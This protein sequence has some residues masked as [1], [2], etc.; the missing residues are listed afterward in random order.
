M[1]SKRTKY[2]ITW[3]NL[4]ITEVWSLAICEKHFGV[5]EFQE[6]LQGYWPHIVAVKV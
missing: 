1:K 6:C 5:E 2:E 4:G 3:I